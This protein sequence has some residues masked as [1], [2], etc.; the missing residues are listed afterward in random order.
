MSHRPHPYGFDPEDAIIFDDCADCHGYALDG[1]AGLDTATFAKAWNRM[2][3]VER[4]GEAYR[5]E[6]EAQLCRSLY[7][8]AVLIDRHNICSVSVWLRLDAEDE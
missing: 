8:M 5:T 3:A 1:G 6:A 2:L 7:R 4:G